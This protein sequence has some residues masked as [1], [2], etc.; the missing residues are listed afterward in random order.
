MFAKHGTTVAIG[1]DSLGSSQSLSVYEE[2]HEAM[3]LHGNS[4]SPL[5]LVR[6]AVKGGHRALG[7]RPPKVGRG[8][9]QTQFQVWGRRGPNLDLGIGVTDNIGENGKI[10]TAEI[11]WTRIKALGF[12]RLRR[13]RNITL[14]HLK[15]I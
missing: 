5:A 14:D 13:L 1:T 4:I 12:I 9:D 6:S 3:A 10:L 8:D 7:L 2:V 15:V 11:G